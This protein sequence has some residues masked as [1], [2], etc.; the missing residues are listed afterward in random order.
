MTET[1]LSGERLLAAGFHTVR[2]SAT[3]ARPGA[4]AVRKVQAKRPAVARDDMRPW[5]ADCTLDD[6]GRPIPNV[7]NTGHVLRCDPALADLIAF[8]QMAS[9]VVLNAPVPEATDPDALPDEGFRPREVTNTDIIALLEYLQSTGLP[10]LG[11]GDLHDALNKRARECAFHPVRDYL[12]ELVW[13]GTPRVSFWMHTY[14]GAA[15]DRY[16]TVI[17]RKFLIAMIAR[18]FQPGCKADHMVVLEGPQGAMKSTACRILG[19]DWFS[20]N[21]PDISV[22]KDAQ[23]HLSGKWLIELAEMSAVSKA[24]DNALKAFLSRAT[25]RLRPQYERVEVSIPRQCV[26]IGTTNQSTY[27]RDETGGRRFWPVKVGRID[28]DALMRDRDQLFAEA[29]YLFQQGEDWWPDANF[30]RECIRPQQEERFECDAWEP[31]IAHYLTG[32]ARVQ[33]QE[34]AR[35]AIGLGLDKTGT[36]ENRRIRNVF[37]RLGWT[38]KRGTGGVRWYVPA[39]ASEE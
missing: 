26:F 19:G 20:D 36:S 6:K 14:L 18:V 34:V 15:K 29:L 31:A 27:L 32:K 7:A 17:G 3:K 22:G 8:D 11:K 38:Q 5:L 4:P 35:E 23:Q 39:Q 21:M 24:E 9:G 16:T 12:N 30:E 1:P 33:V 25:E 28:T 37:L 2:A 13:D 10:R